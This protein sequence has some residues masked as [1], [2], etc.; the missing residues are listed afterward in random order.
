MSQGQRQTGGL[1]GR[2]VPGEAVL[3]RPLPGARLRLAGSELA[4]DAV[5]VGVVGSRRANQQQ[6]NMAAEIVE[7]LCAEG[8]VIV[9]GGALGIDAT[10][11]RT[12]LRCGGITLAVLPSGL[13]VPSPAGH[14]G[15][16][17]D[18]AGGAGGVLSSFADETPA[19]LGQFHARNRVICHVIDALIV[20]CA[21]TRSG[22][23]HCARRAWALGVPVLATPWTPGSPNSLGTNRILAS[24]GRALVD[25][26]GARW[27]VRR[28]GD[29]GGAS[30]LTREAGLEGG[31]T[32]QPADRKPTSRQPRQRTIDGALRARQ[33]CAAPREGPAQA[34]VATGG[35]DPELVA[36]L[37]KLLRDSAEGSISLE[38]AVR[39]TGRTRAEVAATLLTLTLSGQL[40][41]APHGCYRRTDAPSQWR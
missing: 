24:G 25:G 19:A 15:L 37:G 39:Q 31:E 36:A 32:S 17:A 4:A 18:I 8:A 30:L 10:A 40:H 14:A 16:Y 7:G 11:H 12:A 28:L 9:S 5:R 41:R 34:L 35:C 23:L 20:V 13:A 2:T 26:T 33:T 3:R 27:L 1:V 21:D 6:L 29:G 38:M 22:S